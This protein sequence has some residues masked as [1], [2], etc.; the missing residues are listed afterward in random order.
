M[1]RLTV[2]FK[3][4]T[5]KPVIPEEA[6]PSH[7]M[8]LLPCIRFNMNNSESCCVCKHRVGSTTDLQVNSNKAV[9]VVAAGKCFPAVTTIETT[10]R[11]GSPW[12]IL[13]VDDLSIWLPMNYHSLW[14]RS[15]SEQKFVTD[16]KDPMTRTGYVSWVASSPLLISECLSLK[17][18]FSSLTAWWNPL[19]RKRTT[20]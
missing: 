4:P 16:F 9:I 17:R 6:S 20:F 5:E 15:A 3:V 7:D 13:L 10:F 18:I 8:V 19:R 2:H 11:Y 14:L 1:N 12:C